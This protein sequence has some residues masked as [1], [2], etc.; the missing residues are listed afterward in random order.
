MQVWSVN[1]VPMYL[2]S[3]YSVTHAENWAESATTAAPQITATVTS[4]SGALP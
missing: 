3:A 2:G 1:A 4:T